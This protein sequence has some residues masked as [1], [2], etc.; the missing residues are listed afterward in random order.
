[1]PS[2]N[3]DAALK[4]LE[5]G[6]SIIPC[7]PDKKPY[8]S[9]AEYQDKKP[10]EDEVREKWE[11]WPN[12][13]IGLITG[14]ISEIVAV[15]VDDMEKG[16]A[17]LAQYISPSI[18]T[19]MAETPSGGLHL[20][21][22][23]PD[24]DIQNNAGTIPGCDFR[25]D[26]GYILVEPSY[27][28]YD[29]KGKHIEGNYTWLKSI[30]D[31]PLAPLPEAY[32]KALSINSF[33]L[34]NKG[35]GFDHTTQDHNDHTLPQILCEGS[36]D[37]DLFHIANCLIKGGCESS[38]VSYVLEILALISN[39]PFPLNEIKNKIKSALDRAGR[40]D[41]SI[42]NEVKQWVLTTNGHFLTTHCHK[43]L[44]LTTRDHMKSANMALLRLLSAGIIEKYGNQRG[45][46]R[47]IEKDAEIIDWLNAP[48]HEFPIELPFKLSSEVILYPGNVGIFAGSKSSGKT[49][50]AFDIIKRNMNRYQVVYLNSEMHDTEMK[51]R[52]SQH[53]D[54]ALTDWHFKALSVSHP[55]ADYITKEKKL[56]IIDYI[57][58][59]NQDAWKVGGEIK[60]IH[61]K[62]GEGVAIIF[63][64]KKAGEDLAR[65]GQYTLDK[66]RLYV[67]VDKGQA[68]IIDAKSFRNENPHGKTLTFELIKGAKFIYDEWKSQ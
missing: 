30:F 37:N 28:S 19:P 20:F 12:A 5:K 45:A 64:Q 11:R 57:E 59:S 63:L 21:F 25:G 26:R 55:Y 39:P 41:F 8:I 67:A 4:Y 18:E 36:R 46:Y 65:G 35:C 2:T 3:F 43:E 40:R 61:D 22:K 14:R 27:C 24:F 29:K 47:L 38:I 13:N 23:H 53:S 10:T 16:P 51:K 31:V 15:D 58:T 1:M 48:D 42:A 6:F 60:A 52:L 56:F 50:L 32:I 34:Y 9:W 7:R 62:L 49:A 66:A 68:K 44:Q 17:N 33:S 54:L